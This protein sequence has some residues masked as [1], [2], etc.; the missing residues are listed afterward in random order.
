MSAPLAMAFLLWTSSMR[1]AEAGQGSDRGWVPPAL[2]LSVVARDWDGARTVIGPLMTTDFLRPARSTQMLVGRV[3]L[4][5]Q[6]VATFVQLG[7]GSWRLDT[8]LLSR[9]EEIDRAGQVGAGIEWTISTLSPGSPGAAVAVESESTV[10]FRDPRAGPSTCHHGAALA[11][12][13]LV[14]RVWF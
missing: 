11:G 14:A 5:G 13:L 4:S 9:R 6:K 8:P 7:L 12:G 1:A 2:E 3:R 10:L